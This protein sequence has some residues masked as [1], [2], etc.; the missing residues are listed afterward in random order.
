[1]T[2][3][4]V[5]TIDEVNEHM[6]ALIRQEYHTD[7]HSSTGE[8]PEERFFAFPEKYRRFVSK[9][10]LM[11]VFLP[12]TIAKVSKTGLIHINKLEYLV[13]DARLVGKKAEVRCESND[14]SRIY[15]WHDDKYIGEAHLYHKDND[16][17][18]REKI[19][20]QLAD[21]KDFEIPDYSDI[22]PFSRLERRFAAYRAEIES[23]SMEDGLKDVITKREMVKAQ[24][25]EP[26]AQ[27]LKDTSTPTAGA[28]DVERLQHLLAVLLKRRLSAHERF[29]I[30]STWQ[31]YGP[32][33]ED[34][35]RTEAGRLLGEQCENLSDYLDAMR[36]AA[37]TIPVK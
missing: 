17:Q 37:S 2:K 19:L 18:K 13:P 27:E 5:L 22:P 20:S 10:T 32:F 4:T 35:V 9:S 21:T 24:L 34:L 29:A 33:T 30:H 36:I 25:L 6:A 14:M 12:C 23:L 28:F 8:T 31:K 26:P 15:V 11:M 1:M 7:V 16:Y 3:N